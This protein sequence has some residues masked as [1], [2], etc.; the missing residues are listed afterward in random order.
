[1]D[2]DTSSTKTYWERF[3]DIRELCYRLNF[4]KI[5]LGLKP[6]PF[7]EGVDD[8]PAVAGVGEDEPEED[9]EQGGLRD[10]AKEELDVRRRADQLWLH[11]L[12][13]ETE[14]AESLKSSRRLEKIKQTT[15]Y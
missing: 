9:G 5:Y 3:Q 4:I 11:R 12:E 13:V 8:A 7:R 14:Q 15:S 6:E 10:L 1:M 2:T